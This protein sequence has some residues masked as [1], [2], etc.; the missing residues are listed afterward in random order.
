[1]K[2]T[3]VEEIDKRISE[4]ETLHKSKSMSLQE[5]GFRFSNMNTY[6]NLF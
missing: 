2:Y 4:L 1:M 6:P 5:V 3:R